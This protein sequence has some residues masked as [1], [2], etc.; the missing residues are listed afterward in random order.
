MGVRGH[1]STDRSLFG[2]TAQH[3]TRAALCPI[4]TIHET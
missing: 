3:V 2:S 1:A 4:L